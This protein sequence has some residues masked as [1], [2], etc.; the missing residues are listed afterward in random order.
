MIDWYACS[1]QKDILNFKIFPFIFNHQRKEVRRK[2]KMM[3]MAFALVSYNLLSQTKKKKQKRRERNRQWNG[4]YAFFSTGSHL[5]LLP[6][7]LS[8]SS[9]SSSKPHKPAFPQILLQNPISN[10]P[11]PPVIPLL[12]SSSP[13][14]RRTSVSGPP[15]T[16]RRSSLPSFTSSMPFEI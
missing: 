2:V 13:L 12:A 14:T 10:S 6:L 16:G 8:P 1:F 7:L 9:S 4:T 3:A 5:L 11:N 15:T